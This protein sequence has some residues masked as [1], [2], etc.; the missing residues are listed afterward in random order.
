MKKA[1][2]KTN[3]NIMNFHCKFMH[4]YLVVYIQEAGEGSPIQSFLHPFAIILKSGDR[5]SAKN[6]IGYIR[7]KRGTV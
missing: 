1:M 5:N 6:D 2:K 4:F 3:E 7:S